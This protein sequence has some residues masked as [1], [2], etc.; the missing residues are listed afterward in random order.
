M[1]IRLENY[2]KKRVAN[3]HFMSQAKTKRKALI[4][5]IE[6][7]DTAESIQ[8]AFNNLDKFLQKL[9]SRGILSQNKLSNIL[10]KASNLIRSNK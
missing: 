5:I 10:S 2:E 9:R 7:K 8:K 6:K 4:A 1:S 3:K